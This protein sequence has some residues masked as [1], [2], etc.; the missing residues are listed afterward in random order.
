[1]GSKP[2]MATANTAEAM[3]IMAIWLMFKL[4]K[5]I[6]WKL[7][8]SLINPCTESCLYSSFLACCCLWL[9]ASPSSQYSC[10]LI[11]TEGRLQVMTVMENYEDDQ[12]GCISAP[13]VIKGIADTHGFFYLKVPLLLIPVN[14]KGQLYI[15]CPAVCKYVS[16][17]FYCSYLFLI[18][19]LVFSKPAQ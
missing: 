14:I 16:V 7:F 12:G 1:M 10:A 11:F 19:D 13:Y 15:F 5:S 9:L 17:N 2:G 18:P 3:H 8:N 4:Q 6:L